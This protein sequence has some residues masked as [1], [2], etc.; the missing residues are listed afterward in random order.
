MYGTL[1]VEHLAS[2][3]KNLCLIY[4]SNY[5]KNTLYCLWYIVKNK[6]M[7]ANQPANSPNMQQQGL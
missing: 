1:R 2:F 4:Y 7:A 3:N 6:K 5:K